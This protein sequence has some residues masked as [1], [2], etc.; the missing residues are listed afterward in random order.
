MRGFAIIESTVTNQWHH[1]DACHG[2]PLIRTARSIHES[3]FPHESRDGVRARR[4]LCR[5]QRQPT[6]KQT[7]KQNLLVE[8]STKAN[9]NRFGQIDSEKSLIS[10][11]RFTKKP[12]KKKVKH[13]KDPQIKLPL[14][15]AKCRT[16][17]V[18]KP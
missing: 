6:N 5:G 7:N 12:Y 1:G 8:F 10:K 13:N 4:L 18:R 15:T 9:T 11:T 2:Q 14:P 3:E 16:L 17:E